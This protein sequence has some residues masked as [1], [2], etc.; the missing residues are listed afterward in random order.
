VEQEE[1]VVEKS[2]NFVEFGRREIVDFVIVV[3]MVEIQCCC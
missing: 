1:V 2:K 3:G